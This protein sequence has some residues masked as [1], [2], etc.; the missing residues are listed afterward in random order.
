MA[1][2]EKSKEQ[3]KLTIVPCSISD[4]LV[5]IGKWH[6]HHLPPVG[7]LFAVAVQDES[8]EIRGVALVGRPVAR[9]NQDGFTAE[10]TRVATDEC[11]NA[12]S[13][14]Y[15]ACWRAAKALGWRKLITYTLVTEPGTSLRASGWRVVG[16]V[17]GRSWSTP[18]RLRTD[19]HPL[20]DKLR[21]EPAV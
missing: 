16:E 12:C 10:V 19:K 14:L 3:E 9:G 17:K 4:A 20:F 5:L 1:M 2:N 8:G 7:G 13:A 11:E 21:W 15:G 6:R 18:S